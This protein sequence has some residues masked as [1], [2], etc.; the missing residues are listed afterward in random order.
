MVLLSWQSGTTFHFMLLRRPQ[1]SIFPTGKDI[2]VEVRAP[3]EVTHLRG[4]RIAPK[5]IQA[6]NPAFDIT[7]HDLIRGIIT[8]KGMIRKPFEKRLRKMKTE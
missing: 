3:E 7:P 5:E 6:L 8:E 4:V 2:P 1:P